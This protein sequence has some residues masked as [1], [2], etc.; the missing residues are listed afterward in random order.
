MPLCSWYLWST[1]SATASSKNI[2]LTQATSVTASKF[3]SI[4]FDIQEPTSIIRASG[5]R[6][7]NLRFLTP[8]TPLIFLYQICLDLVL[9]SC[10][11]WPR[12]LWIYILSSK[13]QS[14]TGRI[15]INSLQRCTQCAW[16][17][18]DGTSVCPPALRRSQK[19]LR[20]ILGRWT[21]RITSFDKKRISRTG[22]VRI[23]RVETM[24]SGLSGYLPDKFYIWREF[25]S[26]LSENQI[27]QTLRTSKSHWD[28]M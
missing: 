22:V 26:G 12:S 27:S 6:K 18:I 24:L 13:R 11:V 5:R 1:F 16:T 4:N 20:L 14:L 7:R 15:A 19:V 17:R 3:D 9:A 2:P 25:G 23:P 8:E 28:G 10:N 21:A